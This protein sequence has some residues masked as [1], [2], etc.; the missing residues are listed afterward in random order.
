MNLQEILARARTMIAEGAKP[1]EVATFVN[2]MTAGA[3][4]DVETLQA[5]V[6]EGLETVPL[7]PIQSLIRD[8]VNGLQQLADLVV[9]APDMTLNLLLALPGLVRA[10][11]QVTLDALL[12]VPDAVGEAAANPVDT[13]KQAAGFLAGI[14]PLELLAPAPPIARIARG[15]ELAKSK[16]GRRAVDKAVKRLAEESLSAEQVVQGLDD[17]G[18]APG[19]LERLSRANDALRKAD[20]RKKLVRAAAQRE[21]RAVESGI[22][23]ADFFERQVT[24]I[25]DQYGLD[26]NDA[27]AIVTKMR[28][29]QTT[30]Q[31]E[32][33]KQSQSAT[34]TT[35]ALGSGLAAAAVYTSVNP[36]EALA[37]EWNALGQSIARNGGVSQEALDSIPANQLPGYLQLLSEMPDLGSDELMRFGQNMGFGEAGE[38]ARLLAGQSAER[39]QPRTMQEEADSLINDPNRPPLF[40]RYINGA[41]SAPIVG[42]LFQIGDF[43]AGLGD[44]KD[45]PSP[46]PATS[47]SRPGLL[48]RGELGP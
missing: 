43:L 6:S 34:P 8:P 1:F 45:S 22:E 42:N 19:L 9:A 12:Q 33:L 41:R 24:G 4:A 47:S 5:A 46:D 38:N 23:G 30:P 18:R 28:Q 27:R 36:E 2:R 26:V 13:A 40:Q 11:P 35:A 25:I 17:V 31:V 29:P 10:A 39:K 15:M 32:A 20:T 16:A 44:E 7:S 3:T 37:Q 48:T 21:Q 14:Q